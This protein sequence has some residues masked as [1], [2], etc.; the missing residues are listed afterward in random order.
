MYEKVRFIFKR[1]QLEE[2]RPLHDYGITKQS[3]IHLALVNSNKVTI[4][5][6]SLVKHVTAT[7]S[8]L[9]FGSK[10]VE[11]LLMET[12]AKLN[13][14][15]RVRMLDHISMERLFDPKFARCYSLQGEVYG[16]RGGKPYYKPTG[17]VRYA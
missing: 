3:N 16:N 13:K 17:W 2:G 11:H 7:A 9:K 4:L 8:S 1:C 12:L 10:V 14:D 15:D 5:E 6:P